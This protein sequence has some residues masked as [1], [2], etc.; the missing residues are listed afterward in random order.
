MHVP[1]AAVNE[2]DFT[3]RTKD[4][5]GFSGEV[6]AVEA[7]AIAEGVDKTADDEFGLCVR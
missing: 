4:E 7:I 3:A 2:N 5:I 1:K 6:A